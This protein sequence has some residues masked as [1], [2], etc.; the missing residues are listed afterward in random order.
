MDAR[1]ALLC[2]IPC[3]F[4]GIQAREK[5]GINAMF[6]LFAVPLQICGAV[7]ENQ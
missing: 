7:A 3:L 4:H 5:N 6:S 2:G 1:Y